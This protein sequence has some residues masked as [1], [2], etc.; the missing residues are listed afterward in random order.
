MKE[1]V[2][3]MFTFKTGWCMWMAC[4]SSFVYWYWVASINKQLVNILINALYL[5]ILHF[6]ICFC[7]TERSTETLK[8]LITHDCTSAHKNKVIWKFARYAKS[9]W[10]YRHLD[11]YKTLLGSWLL[12]WL[13]MEHWVSIHT[14]K[15]GSSSDT[16]FS[17]DIF[18]S[19]GRTLNTTW[20][21]TD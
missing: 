18:A 9:P 14:Q 8:P 1:G 13:S 16:T 11:S 5:S 12:I 21:I 15:Y 2:V 20:H 10:S 17:Q 4:Q 6:H 19:P 7:S 3:K